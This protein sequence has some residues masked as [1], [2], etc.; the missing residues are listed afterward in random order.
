MAIDP[1][2]LAEN[3]VRSRI[4]SMAREINDSMPRH[5]LTLVKELVDGIKNPTITIL[6][7]S[8]KGDVDDT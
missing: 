2:F 3:S 4:I 5:V 1:W 8:Y 6:G 7:V